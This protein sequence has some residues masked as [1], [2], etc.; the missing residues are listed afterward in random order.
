M[1]FGNYTYSNFLFQST[2]KKKMEQDVKALL[3]G[4]PLLGTVGPMRSPYEATTTTTTN[5]DDVEMTPVVSAIG[6]GG[7]RAVIADAQAQYKSFKSYLKSS[8]WSLVPFEDA[9]AGGGG[10]VSCFVLP[11]EKADQIHRFTKATGTIVGKTADEIARRHKDTNKITR[12]NWDKDLADIG[13]VKIVN[14]NESL[15]ISLDLQWAVVQ[16]YGPAFKRQH[17]FYQWSQ[18]TE[19]ARAVKADII[20][21]AWTIITHSTPHH[22]YP[23]PPKASD[24]ISVFQVMLLEPLTPALSD[25]SILPVPRTSVTLMGWTNPQDIDTALAK[26]IAFLQTVKF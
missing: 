19:C 2:L 8:H 5:S 7:D 16:P 14:S 10:G 12:L 11:C 13:P 1:F 24:R 9:S 3:T 26:R 25:E 20:D 15:G 6:G 17:V 4:I 22:N 18:A 21:H 23:V